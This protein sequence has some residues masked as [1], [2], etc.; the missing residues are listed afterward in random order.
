M[1]DGE[2]DADAWGAH[3]EEDMILT[4]TQDVL[5]DTCIEAVPSEAIRVF[6]F[7]RKRCIERAKLCHWIDVLPRWYQRG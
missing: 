3:S 6:K 4:G 7:W 2:D 1:V 5:L